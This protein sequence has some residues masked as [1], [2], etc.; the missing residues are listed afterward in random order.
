MTTREHEHG[1]A[2]VSA[3]GSVV[4]DIGP[5]VGALVLFTPPCLEGV[6]IEISPETP[7]VP[8]T[9]SLVRKRVTCGQSGASA[10]AD[11]S[12][13]AIYPSLAAGRY[14]IWRDADT[15]AGV[16]TIPEAQVTTWHWPAPAD[17][18]PGTAGP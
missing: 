6:E 9:H 18:G 1:A 3:V 11:F 8:S 14:T 7:A 10:H 4:L 2:G 5:G 16:L 12:Y 15:A 13:A 17:G